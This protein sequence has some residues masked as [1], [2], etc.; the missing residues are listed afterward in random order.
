MTTST[1]QGA[2]LPEARTAELANE[3][4]FQRYHV[5]TRIIHAV[6]ATSFLLLLLSGLVLLVPQLAWLAAGGTSRLLHRIAAVGFISVPILYILFDRGAA[7]ELLVDSFR[8]DKDDIAWLKQMLRYF[9]GRAAEMPPQGRLNAGQKLHHAA[10][11]IMSAVVV[12]SGLVLW[13]AKG[14]LGGSLLALVVIAHVLSMLALTVLLVGHV[15]FTFVYGALPGMTTGQISEE[16]ARLE[17]P[18]WVEELLAEEAEENE[19]SLHSQ[20]QE[21]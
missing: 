6:L 20:T 9:F 16:S 13:F 15:Y 8:Y 21:K 11:V 2:S 1:M 5:A 19:N 10:V 7:R 18:K 4:T 3:R 12:A 14:E 17:H